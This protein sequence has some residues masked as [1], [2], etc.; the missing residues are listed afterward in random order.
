M[1]DRAHFPW[2]LIA[3][4]GEIWKMNDHKQDNI[5]CCPT[6]RDYKILKADAQII[7]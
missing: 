6:K 7:E 2:D 1:K 4:R 5:L 3:H